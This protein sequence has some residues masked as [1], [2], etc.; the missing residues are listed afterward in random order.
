MTFTTLRYENVE[1]VAI[2]TFATPENLN[3]I[4]ETRLDELE[5][6][7]SDC[8][9]NGGVRALILTGEGRAF[10]VGLDLDLLDRAFADLDYFDRIVNRLAAIIARLEA[11]DIP[12]IVA[13][14]GFTRAGGFEL[15]LGC[16]FMIVADEAK[17]GDVHTDA[18]VVPAAVTLRLKRRVGD[19]RA[20]E[21]LWAAQWYKGQQAVDIGLAIKSVPLASLRDEAIAYART[22][23]DKPR[24][25]L[26]TLKRI[27]RD[28]HLLSTTE[29][30]AKE[31]AAFAHYNR[32]EPYGREGYTAFREK[33]LPS[34]K[35]A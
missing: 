31:L 32:T 26:A 6:V 34:W 10:C 28:G 4:T 3:G 23:T 14:N 21:I 15:S 33:R 17:I 5:A 19:Q 22:M 12:T 13:N 24:A 29:G 2:A 18:G 27:M 9:T 20:K 35:A 8:E 30:A 11:L 7:L 16:D 1:G 25:T